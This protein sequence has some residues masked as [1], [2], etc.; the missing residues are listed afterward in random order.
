MAYLLDSD[1]LIQA[2]NA[3]Y[4]FDICPGFWAWIERKYQSGQAFSV[5]RFSMN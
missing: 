2:K 5:E 1:V 4:G 3:H